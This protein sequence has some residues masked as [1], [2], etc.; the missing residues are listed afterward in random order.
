MPEAIALIETARAEGL[1]VMA[2]M[3]SY[4]AS[5]TD[6]SSLIPADIHVGGTDHMIARLKTKVLPGSPV[7]FFRDPV[8]AN[9]VGWEGI[10]ISSCPSNPSYEGRHIQEISML[11]ADRIQW[12]RL[13][14]F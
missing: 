6:L 13:W 1:D 2:D 10:I 5:N 7:Q 14:I 4:P 12:M 11:P 9:G 8:A 3:Y